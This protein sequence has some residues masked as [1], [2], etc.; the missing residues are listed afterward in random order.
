MQ[1]HATIEHA[2][3]I[4]RKEKGKT[5]QKERKKINGNRT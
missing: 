5:M 3:E 2:K 1:Q 4:K